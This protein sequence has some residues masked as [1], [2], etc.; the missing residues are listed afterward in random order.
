MTDPTDLTRRTILTLGSAGAVGGA[1]A[2]AGCAA[3]APERNGLAHG[4]PRA[5]VS[6][7]DGRAADRSAR[8]AARRRGHR[9]ARRR[10]G[11]RQHRRH[12]QRR[13]RR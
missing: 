2:L 10:P 1:L 13:S 4:E 7:A 6:D 11:G 9:G 8:R 12:H 3:D 5:T